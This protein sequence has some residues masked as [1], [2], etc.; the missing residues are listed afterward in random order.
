MGALVN[1][2][3][4]IVGGLLGVLL[5]KK[6]KQELTDSLIT[7]MGICLIFVAI[8][9]II[10]RMITITDG[11]MSSHGTLCL[12]ISMFLGT[13]IGHFLKIND[14]L[15]KFGGWIQRK[16][17]LSNF[18]QGFVPAT[19][20]FC[21]GAMAIL[22]SIQEGVYHK[23]DILICKSII[24]F[25]TA[26]ALGASLGYGVIFASIP[27]LV[28]EGALT[29][30]ASALE[31]VL[32]STLGTNIING[33]CMVGYAIILAIAFNM[34]GIKKIKAGDLV[35]SMLIPI[36]YYWILSFTTLSDF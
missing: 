6:I 7:V 36:L 18:S 31:G 1:F 30:C 10:P 21:I 14:N 9:G 12:I 32:S 28:Y 2:G 29:L 26:L 23:Y 5:K 34:M 17:K 16:F 24:D 3:T 27:I 20:F 22:G 8:I 35:P 15:D 4:I 13:L 19:L 25:I 33:I 11:E